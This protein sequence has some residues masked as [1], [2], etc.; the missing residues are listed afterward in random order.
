MGGQDEPSLKSGAR[1]WPADHTRNVLSL[2]NL[3][4]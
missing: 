4:S 1:F 2:F 3:M